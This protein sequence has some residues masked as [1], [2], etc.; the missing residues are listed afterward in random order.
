[1]HILGSYFSAV[2]WW[3]MLAGIVSMIELA[4]GPEKTE[5]LLCQSAFE[6]LETHVNCF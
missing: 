6:P 2:G 1:M 3:M 4:F 5:K